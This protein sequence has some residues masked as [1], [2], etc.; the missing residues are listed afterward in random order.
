MREDAD[1]LLFI[2]ESIERIERFIKVGKEEFFLNDM[3]QDAVVRNFQVIG[4]AIKDLS[5]DLRTSYPHVNWKEAAGLRDKVVH[6]YF[7]VD[8]ET[9]WDSAENDL[10]VLK[11]Q[12]EEIQHERGYRT[13]SFKK[14]LLQE[15]LKDKDN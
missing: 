8:L 10:P 14:S 2:L 11:S 6:D 4:Q 12:I 1:R 5:Q 15:K 7:D 9:I 13:K 3:V